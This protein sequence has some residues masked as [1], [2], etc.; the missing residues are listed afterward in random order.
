MYDN[1]LIPFDS[2]SYGINIVIFRKLN[3][4]GVIHYTYE[5]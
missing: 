3:F 5:C 1:K 4:Y 2:I